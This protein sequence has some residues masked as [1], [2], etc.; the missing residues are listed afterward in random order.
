MNDA[1]IGEPLRRYADVNYAVMKAYS[2][3]CLD[4]KYDRMIQELQ[5]VDWDTAAAEGG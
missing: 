5:E 1:S 2:T 3:K 4:F